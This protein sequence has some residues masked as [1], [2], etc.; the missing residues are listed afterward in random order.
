M[1]EINTTVHPEI[2]QG[3]MGIGVSSWELASNVSQM[4]HLGVVSGTA[5]DSV[6]IRT[7]QDGDAGGH[8]RRALEH[9]PIA[10]VSNQIIAKYFLADGRAPNAPYLDT[11]KLTL[12][13]SD[14]TKNLLV[15]SAFVEV[16]LAK[17][18]HCGKIGINLLEKIQMALPYVI[19]GAMIARVDYILIGA[20]VPAHIPALIQAIQTGEETEIRFDLANSVE[21]EISSFNPR[22]LKGI[23]FP[24]HRPFFLAIVSGHVLI[25]YLNKDLSTKPDGFI[26]EMHVAGGHNAPPRTKGAIDTKGHAIYSSKDEPDLQKIATSGSPFW[27]A[28]G[29]DSPADYRKAKSLGAVGVQVGTLFALCSESGLQASLRREILDQLEKDSLQIVTDANASPTGYPFKVAEIAGTLSEDVN[30]RARSR[31]CDLGYLR[32]PFKRIN[33][34]IGYRC[35]AEPIQNFEF[36]LGSKDSSASAK[37]LCNA[38]MANIGLGQ[39]RPGGNTE[40]PLVTLGSDLH[41][42]REMLKRHPYGW[43]ASNVIDYLTEIEK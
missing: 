17:E 22:F 3:G 10:E 13:P 23:S 30:F 40:L 38:L 28:G 6:V 32:L 31:I 14:S 27:L 41:G 42:C 9:F 36:K 18:G 43:N 11:P 4:G 34:S 39:I 16:W 19:L 20:G 21:K 26:V 33:G 25:K 24:L 1:T 2:I 29:F 7:L 37:C 8:I 12:R 15:A 35:P 5:I